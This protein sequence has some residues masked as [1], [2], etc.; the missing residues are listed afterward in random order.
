MPEIYVLQAGDVGRPTIQAFGRTWMVSNFLGQVMPQDVGKYVYL[1]G[2][3]LQ[4]EN[5]EQRDKREV[6]G[7][8]KG[9]RG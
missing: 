6:W 2:G 5:D 4:V 8:C 1:R 9:M 3:T 7:R